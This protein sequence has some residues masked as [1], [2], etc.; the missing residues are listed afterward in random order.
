[1]MYCPGWED[2][3]AALCERFL[4][5][6][7]QRQLGGQKVYCIMYCPG[8]KVGAVA[9]CGTVQAGRMVGLDSNWFGSRAGEEGEEKREHG[10]NYH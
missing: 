4:F 10:T 7:V 2:V 1:M 9:P 5:R 6:T 8:V 3:G